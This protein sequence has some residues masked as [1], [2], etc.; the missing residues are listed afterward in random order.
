MCRAGC[1]H[2]ARV[3]DAPVQLV[4]TAIGIDTDDESSLVR[5]GSDGRGHDGQMECGGYFFFG[6]GLPGPWRDPGSLTG[7]RPFTR[8]DALILFGRSTRPWRDPGSLTGA[9]GPSRVLS[10]FSSPIMGS[11]RKL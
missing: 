9:P 7:A 3:V 2:G 8:S 4:A 11:V 1:P 5:C 10:F 6:G